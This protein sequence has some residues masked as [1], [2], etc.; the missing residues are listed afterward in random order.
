MTQPDYISCHLPTDGKSAYLNAALVPLDGVTVRIV[1]ASIREVPAADGS[2]R[3][4]DKIVLDV[5]DAATGAPMKSYLPCPTMKHVLERMFGTDNILAW[6]GARVTL[7]RDP[8]VKLKGKE[9]G[10]IRA[11]GSPDLEGPIEVEVKIGR[12][13]PYRITLRRT[14]D[15]NAR[16]SGRGTA[17]GGPA[18]APQPAPPAPPAPPTLSSLGLT[19]AGVNALLQ[20][21]GRPAATDA[22]L[23]AILTR[24]AH[25]DSAAALARARELSHPATAADDA[26]NT[27]P[28]LE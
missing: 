8:K 26:A 17:K 1:D 2:S 5:V 21:K 6:I 18:P 4:S 3:P 9:V 16:P 25:P 12:A 27:L 15:P 19:R 13:P 10:G 24:L 28:D 14:A 11:L 23:S 22:T 20:E 7:Y